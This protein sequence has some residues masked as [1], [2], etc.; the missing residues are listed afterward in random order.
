MKTL[1]VLFLLLVSPIFGQSLDSMI[2]REVPSLLTTYKTFH[3]TPE[4]SCQEE[5]TSAVVAAR[6]REL[7]YTVADHIG[8]Y[9]EPGLVGYGVVAMMKNG[10]GPVLLVRSDMDALPVQEQTGLP[11]ASTVATK[12]HACGHDIHMTTLL[13]T[14]KM[15]GQLKSQW[16]GTLLLVGQPA[17]EVVKGASAMLRD[18]LYDRFP[19][20]TYAI[21]IHDNASMPAGQIGYTPGYFMASAD[22]VN[23]TIRGLGG[24]GAAPQSTKDPIV[25][26]AEVILALQTIV[27]RENSPLDPAVVTVGSIHGGTKRNIIPDEVQL[28]LT[29]RTYKPEV[30]KR[31]LASIERVAKGIALAAGIPEE[32]APIF[33]L[34]PGES[35][36]STYNDPAL[37]ERLAQA[38]KRGMGVANV[39]QM[40]PLMVS[41]DFGRFGLDHQIPVVMLNVGAVDPARIARGERLPSL[42]S[43]QFAP[44]PEPTIRGAVK[45]MTLAALE[46]LR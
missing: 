27:S 23:L 2:D 40:D 36:D 5:K 33:E 21:A 3:A 43:S 44:L 41:E 14:A 42:H 1:S 20:P 39:V 22:S 35:T 31:V 15:L 18:G 24:H 16:H 37:T 26:A 34:L 25:V 38:L 12:M 28:Q 30:R 11:Y 46:L 17:E 8:K 6:L 9:N 45:A 4:L 29:V 19:R 32:R 13:G 10:D 7:G